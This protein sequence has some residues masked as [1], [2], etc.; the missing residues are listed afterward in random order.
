MFSLLGIENYKY[1]KMTQLPFATSG[2]SHPKLCSCSLG[3]MWSYTLCLE[4]R[5]D[6]GMKE[7]SK[8]KVFSIVWFHRKE[9]GKIVFWWDPCKK[10]FR[11]F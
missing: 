1:D 11:P 7:S 10:P 8:P 4:Q 6:C 9:E 2:T 3:I 5:K